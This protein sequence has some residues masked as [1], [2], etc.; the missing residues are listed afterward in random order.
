MDVECKCSVCGKIGMAKL[1]HS[2]DISNI[3]EVAWKKF[4]FHGWH[5]I[6][7]TDGFGNPVKKGH[8]WIYYCKECGGR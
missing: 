2:V 3:Y 5:R 8:E 7:R 4:V 6:P 1:P